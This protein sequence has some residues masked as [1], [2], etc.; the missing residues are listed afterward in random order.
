MVGPKST[1]WVGHDSR[2]RN[3]AAYAATLA[4]ILS[5]AGCNTVPGEKYLQVHRE[6]LAAKEHVGKLENQ[7]ADEQ[8]TVRN[9]QNQVAT[10]R[11][12]SPETLKDLV[13]PV[14]IEL[15]S[16]SG[17]YG[18]DGKAGDQGIV[19]YIQPIDQDGDVI[20]AAG[21]IR[22]T[23]LDLSVPTSPKVVS[24]Y[25]FD[26]PTT[27][28]KWYGRLMTYHYTIRCPWPPG[29]LPQ[30]DKITAVV[31]FTDLLTGRVLTAQKPFDIKRPPM[32]AS[33]PAG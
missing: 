23:L 16:R 5:M 32:P 31:E 20:K 21:S 12:I 10:A 11:N 19:L 25:D 15:A 18:T 9:L 6:L 22:V 8:K 14:R 33:K 3:V 26:V 30:A 4:A 13:A 1:A 24:P 27:R 29:S 7:L 28:K 17:G 2:R